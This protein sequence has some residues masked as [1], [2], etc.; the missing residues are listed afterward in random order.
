VK[1]KAN[2]IELEVVD[3]GKGQG[4]KPAVLLIMGLGV[5]L[6]FWPHQ[7]IDAL[8]AAGYRAIC[9]DNRDIGLSQ[10]FDGHGDPNLVWT[11]TKLRLGLKVKPPYTLQDMAADALGVLDALQ[12]QRAHVVG[13]SMGGMIAQRVALAAPERVMSLTS[14]MSTSSAPGLPA[15]KGELLRFLVK[16]PPSGRDGVLEHGLKLW[17]L[18]QG[19]SLR[20]SDEELKVRLAAAYDRS[21]HPRGLNRQFLA[22][23]ADSKRAFE[24]GQVKAPTLVIHGTDDPL[25]PYACGE[26]TARRIPGAKLVSIAGMGHD[27]PPGGREQVIEAL[28]PHLRSVSAPVAV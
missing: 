25:L 8:V 12:V 9:F 13:V 4:D 14:I 22:I 2:G 28:M 20:T 15:A 18:L 19:T 23:L 7:L 5:Q 17:Q 10:F 26:D 6:T 21:H 16:R 1:V 3:S 24:L 27:F 11:V